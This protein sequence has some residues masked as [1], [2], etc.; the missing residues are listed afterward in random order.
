[1]GDKNL[2]EIQKKRKKQLRSK[3]AK[4]ERPLGRSF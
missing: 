4:K 1:M 2:Q 3:A